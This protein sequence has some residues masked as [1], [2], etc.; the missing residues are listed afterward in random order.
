MISYLVTHF[1]S[2][3]IGRKHS[4]PECGNEFTNKAS[5]TKHLKSLHLGNKHPLSYKFSLSQKLDSALILMYLISTAIM[6]LQTI[7]FYYIGI[8]QCML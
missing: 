7:W 2:V 1:Q 3:H 8:P 5:L 4:C 6:T